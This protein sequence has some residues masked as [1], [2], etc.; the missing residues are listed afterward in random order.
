MAAPLARD[1]ANAA[2]PGKG[3]GKGKGR[4]ERREERGERRGGSTTAAVRSGKVI[5]S[6]ASAGTTIYLIII[7]CV[8]RNSNVVNALFAC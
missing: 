4:G 6:Q 3:K 2:G 7:N 8:H 1:A 5:S